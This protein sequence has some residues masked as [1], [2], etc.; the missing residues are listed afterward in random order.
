MRLLA[1]HGGFLQ[2]SILGPVLFNIFINNLDTV[3]CTVSN[4]DLQL[5]G[6]MESFKGREAWR[7][8]SADERAE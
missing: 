4:S 3:E 2:N 6:V 1:S 7:E 5:R 8:I